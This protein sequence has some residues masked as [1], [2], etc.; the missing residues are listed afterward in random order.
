[1]QKK[2]FSPSIVQY[3]RLQYIKTTSRFQNADF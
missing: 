3:V 2:N 1:M